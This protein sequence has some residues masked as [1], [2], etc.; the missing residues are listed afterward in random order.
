MRPLPVTVIGGFLGAGK[1]TLLNRWLAG[2][3]GMRLAVL[4][5]DFGALNVDASLLAPPGSGTHDDADDDALIALTNG[6]VCCQIGDDLG[7]AFDRVQQRRERFD[8]IVVEASGVSDP[9]RIAQYP[10]ADP[11]LALDGIV[12]LADA[13]VL[14]SQLQDP[15]LAD[16]L[17][18]QLRSAGF[19][20]LN[21][22]DLVDAA[23]LADAQQRIRAIAGDLPVFVTHDA[24]VPTALLT[25][26]ALRATPAAHAC[27]PGCDHDPGHAHGHDH[28]HD[29]PHDDDHAHDADDPH[30][31][32]RFD[33]WSARPTAGLDRDDLRAFLKSTP[34][35][36]LRLKGHVPLA[37]GRWCLVQYAGR[38]GTLR[39]VARP[40]D[41]GA[42]VAIGLAN[43]LPRAL[44]ERTFGAGSR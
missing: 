16:T 4:V 33:T 37:D 13:S 41:G 3:G 12:V 35:G 23:T 9:W 39:D 42:V 38:H 1:T 8:A 7:A 6:C 29:H 31:G 28:P 30:H 5:N 34:A 27:A 21:K 22:A 17:E 24:A 43:R 25:G 19:V 18:R 2:A 15:L 36:L 26:L 14:A 32:D 20:V 10:L 44:L 11:G 40:A